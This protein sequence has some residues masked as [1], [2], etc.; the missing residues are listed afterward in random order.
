M[1]QNGTIKTVQRRRHHLK[2]GDRGRIEIG[3]KSFTVEVVEDRGSVGTAGRNLIRVRLITSDQNNDATFEIPA[4]ELIRT[5]APASATARS[6][7]RHAIA[8]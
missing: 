2:P 4:E 8:G 7:R 3:D 1:K 6:K 5:P